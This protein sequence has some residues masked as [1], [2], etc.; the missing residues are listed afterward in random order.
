MF[1]SEVRHRAVL[2]VIERDATDDA[3][4]AAAAAS[5]S[6]CCVQPMSDS[7]SQSVPTGFVYGSV[8]QLYNSHS[9]LHTEVRCVDDPVVFLKL[10]LQ[11]CDMY[12]YW[13]FRFCG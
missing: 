5:G 11:Q 9:N 4:A 6:P 2:K 1:D 12:Q 8:N 7:M 13:Y 10:F 3:V